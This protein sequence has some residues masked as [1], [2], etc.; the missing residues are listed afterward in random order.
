MSKMEHAYEKVTNDPAGR[1][2]E[3]LKLDDSR[4]AVGEAAGTLSDTAASSL[5]YLS[6]L[7]PDVLEYIFE[8][9]QLDKQTKPTS[10]PICKALLPYQRAN[11]YRRVELDETSFALFARA[12]RS[13]K[14]LGS[15]VQKLTIPSHI[16]AGLS[17]EE[18]DQLLRSLSN[19]GKLQAP[20]WLELIA[21]IDV[22]Q[23]LPQLA[24]LQD[25]CLY[26]DLKL[27]PSDPLRH[28]SLLPA[29]KNLYLIFVDG[30]ASSERKI[31]PSATVSSLAPIEGLMAGSNL[32][33]PEVADSSSSPAS[34]S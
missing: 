4:E 10:H 31:K 5:D 16:K 19:L 2:L 33:R 21:D 25:L 34:P 11:L 29:L 32:G 27:L 28:L 26:V 20:H 9:L 1:S 3:L 7:L 13:N 23:V 18:V 30:D 14:G 6:T 15:I 22:E 8:L 17:T 24:Q 12:L